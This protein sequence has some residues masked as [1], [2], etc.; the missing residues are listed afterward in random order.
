MP[1]I[2]LQ[3]VGPLVDTDMINLHEINLFIGKQSTG[4]STLLKILCYCR[5]IEKLVATGVKINGQSASYA[6]THYYKFIKDLIDFYRFNSDYFNSSSRIF[7]EGETIRIEHTGG[8]AKNA[9]ITIINPSARYNSKI[10]FIPSE[11]NLLGVVRDIQ[12]AY[13]SNK[14]DMVFNFLFEWNEVKD[15]F[16][17]ENPL[18]LVA[19][20]DVEYFY[21]QSA[22]GESLKI[23][24]PHN[25]P[26]KPL[27]PFYASS[28]VQSAF[29]LEV[30]V[31]SISDLV[32]KAAKVS[33]SHL[34]MLALEL[35]GNSDTSAITADA[36]KKVQDSL[37]YQSA[38]FFIEEP[39]QNLF[40]DSQAA[41]IKLIVAAVKDAIDKKLPSGSMAVITSHSP[42]VLSTL[43]TLM[44]ASEA[45]ELAPDAVSD[46]ISPRYILPR[47]SY[48]AFYITPEGSVTE[49][50]DREIYM[51][52][53]TKLDY[54]SS[55]IEDKLSDLND[56]IYSHRQEDE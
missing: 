24:H 25:G 44:A 12:S 10:C 16:K 29:P 7:Y 50:I 36:V 56:I 30:M 8:A 6:Y 52:D 9:R 4:K 1:R 14:R 41:V 19:A 34:A 45:Y 55:E 38:Q 23:K 32:G 48:G 53:G 15:N 3:N 54:A 39:E 20:P 35:A 51:I 31:S 22:G 47:N 40:P 26:I 42:Y 28:G 2:H 11:R 46:I 5:W 33:Q 21:D 43:N 49:I 27:S 13:L 17:K 37:I 18:R